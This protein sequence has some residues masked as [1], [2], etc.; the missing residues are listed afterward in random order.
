M[1]RTSPDP[2]V[3][4]DVG[5][6]A[7]PFKIDIL[8]GRLLFVRVSEEDYRNSPFLDE[9]LGPRPAAWHDLDATR[10]LLPPSRL[11]PRAGA[12]IFHIGHCGSTLLSH[13]LS[14]DPR[15][16]PL[17]EPLALR[18]L[19]EARRLLGRPDALT[20]AAGWA[21]WHDLLL[22][23]FGRTERPYDRTLVK[24]TSTCNNLLEPTLDAHPET[25][26]IALYVDL[27]T[28]LAGMLRPE[29]LNALY[30]AADVR[31]RDLAELGVEAPLYTLSVPEL[32][33]VNWLASVLR[34]LEILARRPSLARRLRLVDFSSV[35]DE[36]RDRIEDLARFLFH[37]RDL[38]SRLRRF[39][40]RLLERYAKDQRY[41]F[42]PLQRQ[43]EL[44]ANR[45]RHGG[46]IT[47]TLAWTQMLL[48]AHP[49]AE[50]V[51]ALLR[52]RGIA[53]ADSAADAS[54]GGGKPPKP[55]L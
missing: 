28:Y 37:D 24:A 19:A 30:S 51:Q 55:P 1:S 21:V 44:D 18:A 29:T 10:R 43:R 31:A 17:R 53:P 9:R 11:P 4:P 47:R 27:E 6:G 8:Q 54:Q 7:F 15:L 35:L 48:A 23:L 26:A 12:W 39:D 34:Y 2:P 40:P 33:A 49:L 13:L 45:A 42:D 38:A 36:P 5:P 14:D 20:D 25:R 3:V 22:R 32:A 52:P 46:A 16:L 41:P 50:E